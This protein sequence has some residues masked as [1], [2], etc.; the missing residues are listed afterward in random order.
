MS[1]QLSSDPEVCYLTKIKRPQCNLYYIHWCKLFKAPAVHSVGHRKCRYSCTVY[2]HNFTALRFPS[3]LS[4]SCSG[5]ILPVNLQQ[6]VLQEFA[7]ILSNK[8]NSN[9]GSA[10][11]LRD[12]SFSTCWRGLLAQAVAAG[13]ELGCVC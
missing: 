4:A 3:K 8:A 6:T 9:S 11:L 12:D 13:H 7:E 2:L 1:E 5:T 10:I